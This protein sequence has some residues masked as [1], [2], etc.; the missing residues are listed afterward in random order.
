MP[1]FHTARCKGSNLLAHTIYSHRET[2]SHV[3]TIS[4]NLEI[5]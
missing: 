1:H 2:F 4:M 3:Q 5:T